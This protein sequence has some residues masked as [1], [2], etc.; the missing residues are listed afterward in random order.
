MLNPMERE[1][2]EHGYKIIATMAEGMALHARQDGH[3]QMADFMMALVDN[4]KKRLPDFV[5]MVNTDGLA[6]VLFYVEKATGVEGW[7]NAD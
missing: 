6:A 2:F 1:A 4:A 5:D 3:P 7:D